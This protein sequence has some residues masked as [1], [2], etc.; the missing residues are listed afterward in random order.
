M[1]SSSYKVVEGRVSFLPEDVQ[2]EVKSLTS[3]AFEVQV[4]DA[5]PMES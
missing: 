2:P 1:L 5:R 4:T 3:E